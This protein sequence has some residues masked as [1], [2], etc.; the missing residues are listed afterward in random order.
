MGVQANDFYLIMLKN[1][2]KKS[3][4]LGCSQFPFNYAFRFHLFFSSPEAY[5]LDVVNLCNAYD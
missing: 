4:C 2:N 3:V 1:K 5:F